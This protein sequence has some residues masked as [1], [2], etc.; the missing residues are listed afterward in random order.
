MR[1]QFYRNSHQ[2]DIAG[3]HH[4]G[5]FYVGEDGVTSIEVL[6]GGVVV[7]ERSEGLPQIIITPAGYAF[8]GDRDPLTPLGKKPKLNGGE[9][10][11]G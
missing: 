4:Q 7:I 2:L 9:K 10:K 5:S 6:G 1:V 3:K 11:N 8:G